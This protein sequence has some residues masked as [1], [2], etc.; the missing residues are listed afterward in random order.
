MDDHNHQQLPEIH[1]TGNQ[2]TDKKDGHGTCPSFVACGDGTYPLSIKTIAKRAE[3]LA[4]NGGKRG[5]SPAFILLVKKNARDDGA[6]GLGIT[7]TRKIGNAVVRNRIKR[8]FR[9]LAQDILPQYGFKGADHVFIGRHAAMTRN[10][11]QMKRDLIRALEQIKSG[12]SSRK[13]PYKGSGKNKGRGKNQR[14]R[15]KN[16]SANAPVAD[17]TAAYGA[18]NMGESEKGNTPFLYNKNTQS[19]QIPQKD[20]G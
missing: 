3:F 19:P 4:A 2:A 16:R 7:V 20:K 8:R 17:K 1:M 10:F 6:A 12:R 14:N 13:P 18:A 9:A 11:E 5:V 15:K